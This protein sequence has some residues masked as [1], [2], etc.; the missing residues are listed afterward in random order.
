M[1]RCLPLLKNIVKLVF[2]VFTNVDTQKLR[3]GI[4]F[5]T[6]YTTLIQNE[7]HNLNKGHKDTTSQG[8]STRDG[9]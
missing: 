8:W 9:S 1:H 3:L 6:S 7:M 2:L 5:S 4:S